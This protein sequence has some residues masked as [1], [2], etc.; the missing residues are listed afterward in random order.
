MYGASVENR[1]ATNDGGQ[2]MTARRARGARVPGWPA[3]PD[4]APAAEP[5]TLERI[6]D[7]AG[8]I[9][10]TDGLEALS[11]RRLGAELGAGATSVYWHVRNKD[12][13][14]DL[15][16]DRVIGEIVDD[17]A[18]ADGW[19]EEM[20]E[21]ARAA[22]RVLI[23]HRHLATILGSRPTFGPNSIAA[24]EW[25]LGRLRAAGFS[26]LSATLGANAVTNW[27]S[28][29][30][31]FEARDPLGPSATDEERAALVE[32]ITQVFAGLP[33]DEYPNMVAMMPLVRSITADS[34]F[35]SGLGWLLDGLEAELAR[36]RATPG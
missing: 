17:I 26:D 15:L 13:L 16:V 34:Q 29:Y 31:V 1:A 33:P 30:A 18:P 11:M 8:R 28:G 3:A 35:E 10:D 36:T 27:A 20:A 24:L 6:L 2:R 19:R 7:T 32:A 25:M 14:L 12:E 4:H 5:L 23:R 9:A 21:A 22:R